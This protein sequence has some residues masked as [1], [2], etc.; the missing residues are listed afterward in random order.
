[1]SSILIFRVKGKKWYTGLPV[2]AFG[3]NA[4]HECPS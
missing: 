4:E 3:P 1:M 2:A